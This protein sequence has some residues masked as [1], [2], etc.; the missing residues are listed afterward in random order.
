MNDNVHV[1][2][3][4]G[5]SLDKED[6]KVLEDKLQKYEEYKVGSMGHM[7]FQEDKDWY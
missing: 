4:D 7:E 1:R 6:E 5:Y 2:I 3:N